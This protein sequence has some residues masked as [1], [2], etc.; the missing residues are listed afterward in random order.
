MAGWQPDDPHYVTATWA[1]GTMAL[2]VDG[3]PVGQQ[4][5]SDGFDIPSGTPVY[6]GTGPQN[7]SV[8][9]GSLS[10]VA[11]S[12]EPLGPGEIADRA[13]QVLQTTN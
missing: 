8:A 3:K 2:Y 12:N 7:A 13:A 6:V 5:Y 9:P 11:L 10:N 1:D 4:R